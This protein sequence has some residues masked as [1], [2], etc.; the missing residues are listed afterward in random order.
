LRV[1]AQAEFECPNRYGSQWATVSRNSSEFT[2]G[3]S[4]LFRYLTLVWLTHFQNIWLTPRV[5]ESDTKACRAF[6]SK[7]SNS[8]W[9]SGGEHGEVARS[10]SA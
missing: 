8:S 3:D 2:F 7:L 6:S 1:Q 9:R 4:I 10:R 5:I